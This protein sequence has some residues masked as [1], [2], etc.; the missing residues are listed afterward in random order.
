MDITPIKRGEAA[1]QDEEHADQQKVAN[2]PKQSYWP[3][4]I[5]RT[6]GEIF[7]VGLVILVISVHL[8]YLLDVRTA[9][10]HLDDWN[11]LE[12]MFRALDTHRVSAWIFDSTNGHFLVPAALA[13]LF[14]WR[15]LALDLAP[16]KFL[17]FPICVV[18]FLLVAH[19]IN[20]E[21]RSRFLRFYLYAGVSFIIF[22]LC[23]WEHFALG[24]GFAALLST[25]FGG[26]SLYYFAKVAQPS[27]P[28][29]S[30]LLAGLL[31]LLGSILSLG[32]GYA[33]AVAALSLFLITSL[34]RA[35]F[36]R[37]LPRYETAASYVAFAFGLLGVVSHPFFQ[38]KSRILRAFF[39]S[40][41]V[42]GAVGSS[43]LDRNSL[44]AQNVAFVCGLVLVI[45]SLWIGLHFWRRETGESRLLPI[46]S[47]ALVLFG[48]FG[49]VA[50]AVG[51]SYLPVGEF[52]NSRYTLYPSLCL[53]GILLYF[54]CSKIFLLTNMWCFTAAAYLLATVREN[55]V[56][57][58]R[59]GV[60]RAMEVAIRTP[61]NLSDDQLRAAL[62][63][64]ENTKGVR[65]VAA[66]LRK[67]RL[68]VFRSDNQNNTPP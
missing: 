1:G 65:K 50:V 53:L 46:F 52:L 15:Y 26:V 67:D 30:S 48:L 60:Y 43:F 68:N 62:R 39:H 11:L 20:A 4:L 66:R 44:V 56:G 6:P 25:L 9:V 7:L 49:C 28:W 12:K 40:V 38:L 14:S 59:P 24:S 63:W 35:L 5:P 34:K 32:A 37:S 61:E 64:R 3:K 21:I 18:A 55:Q 19:V 36:S 17:N 29:K 2:H 41:L 31:F 51:R 45:A 23:F 27:S 13:Y 58:Y 42:M 22:S 10:P 33:A 54:A 57:F 16:L 47:L 8:Q